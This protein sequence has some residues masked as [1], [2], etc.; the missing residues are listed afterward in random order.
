[1]LHLRSRETDSPTQP[2]TPPAEGPVPLTDFE[3]KNIEYQYF[4]DVILCLKPARFFLY[5]GKNQCRQF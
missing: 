4:E 3:C 2:H 5:S 1:M